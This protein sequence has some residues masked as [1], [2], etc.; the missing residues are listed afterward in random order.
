MNNPGI[1]MKELRK[2]GARS[3]AVVKV[4]C[5]KMEGHWFETQ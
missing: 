5:Y 3:S 4:L 1:F 2:T